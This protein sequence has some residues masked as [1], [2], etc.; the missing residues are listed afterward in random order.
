MNG[1]PS[2]D[3]SCLK[4]PGGFA[5]LENPLDWGC[6]GCLLPAPGAIRAGAERC[7]SVRAPL[8]RRLVVCGLSLPGRGL[9]CL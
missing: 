5:D 6:P 4:A 8:L 3:S 2:R 9:T 1:K 7:Q